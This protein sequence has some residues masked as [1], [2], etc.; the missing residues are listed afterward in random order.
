M[1]KEGTLKAYNTKIME[2]PSYLEVW[3]YDEPILYRTEIEKQD[4]TENTTKKTCDQLSAID[5]AESLKRKQRH[6][7]SMR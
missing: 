3:S 2:T 4:S 6:Y 7:G 5:Q 1:G